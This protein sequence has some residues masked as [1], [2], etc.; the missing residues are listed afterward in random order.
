[1]FICLLFPE[2]GGGV[3]GGVGSTVTEAKLSAVMELWEA[4]V[5]VKVCDEAD[6]DEANGDEANG[7]EANCDEADCEDVDGVAVGV[8]V[9]D[10]EVVVVACAE[11]FA[12]TTTTRH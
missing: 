1:M 4:C 2:G 9:A 3:V 10:E 6:C 5:G 7:D 12:N 8:A 11:T